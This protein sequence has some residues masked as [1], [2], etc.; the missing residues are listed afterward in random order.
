MSSA[1]SWQVGSSQIRDWTCV[2]CTDRW[3][4]YH[5]A[6]REVAVVRIYFIKRCSSVLWLTVLVLSHV[7]LFCD[8]MD[9]NP[10]GSSVHWDSPGKNTGVSCHF[11]LQKIFPTQASNTCLLCL[12]HWQADSLWLYHMESPQ[13]TLYQ[14]CKISRALIILKLSYEAVTFRHCFWISYN[15]TLCFI[16]RRYTYILHIGS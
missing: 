14:P 6:T 12:L 10:S 2:S 9:C 16:K 13:L 4:L 7:Q 8:P 11:L 5:R 15:Y 3:I 1:D